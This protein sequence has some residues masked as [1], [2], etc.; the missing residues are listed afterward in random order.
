MQTEYL[1]YQAGDVT[2]EGYVAYPDDSGA[3]RPAVLVCHTWRGQSEAERERAEALARLGYVGF[4]VDLYGKGVRGD[5]PETNEKLMRP[6][7]HDRAMLRRRLL[8]AL[9][10]VRRLPRADGARLGAIGYCFGGL[11][12]LDIA[13]SGAEGVRG[14]VSFHGV[15]RPPELGAQAPITAKVLILHGWDDPLAP[16]EHA[17]AIASELSAAGAD[18]Q[19][20]AYGGTAHAF[21][22]PEANLPQAGLVYNAAAARRAWRSAEDFLA[23]A[24]A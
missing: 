22:N 10:T 3:K 2:C 13:R 8:A 4:A 23:E 11:C 21:T 15:L 1:D 24:L 16:P 19:L 20:H 5:S 7:V 14:V 18:W 6:F 9:E 12:A 17:V